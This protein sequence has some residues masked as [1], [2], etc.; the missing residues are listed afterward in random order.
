MQYPDPGAGCSTS[1]HTAEVELKKGFSAA[2]CQPIMSSLKGGLLVIRA[3]KRN[4]L[5][6]GVEGVYIRE[7]ICHDAGKTQ[8]VGTFLQE[9]NINWDK[10]VVP[11][12]ETIM[13]VITKMP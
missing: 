12:P 1:A 4:L 2:P 8:M 7:T 10:H 11:C 6:E 3:P 13:K 5:A 9:V